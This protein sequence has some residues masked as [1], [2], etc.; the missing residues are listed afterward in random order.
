[1]RGEELFEFGFE[2]GAVAVPVTGSGLDEEAGITSGAGSLSEFVEEGILAV[3]GGPDGEV[4]APGD[5][6]LGGFPEQARVLVFGEF[7]EANVAAVNGHGLRMS[8]E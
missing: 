7:V 1:M 3:V 4:A 8:G 5:A 2:G 6:A